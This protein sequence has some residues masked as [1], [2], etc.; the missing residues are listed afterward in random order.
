MPKGDGHTTSPSGFRE[1]CSRWGVRVGGSGGVHLGQ[2][3]DWLIWC[4]SPDTTSRG[5][6]SFW[7]NTS[8]SHSVGNLL[9]LNIRCV[10][11]KPINGTFQ[12][13][14][15]QLLTEGLVL[16]NRQWLQEHEQIVFQSRKDGSTFIR[17]PCQKKGD[18][19]TIP[20]QGKTAVAM[21]WARH[22]AALHRLT[23][24]TR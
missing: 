18:Y 17:K 1:R 14:I 19:L 2:S 16:E 13:K 24:Q 20:R 12:N 3:S 23:R 15:P 4:I 9:L 22:G 10:A 7:T 11:D 5:I 8:Y 21:S 6:S